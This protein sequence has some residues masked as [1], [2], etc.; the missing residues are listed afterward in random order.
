MAEV[1]IGKDLRASLGKGLLIR[2][3][4]N[5]GG[6]GLRRITDVR[7]RAVRLHIL[8]LKADAVDLT[9]QESKELRLVLCNNLNG[10]LVC[11]IL[12]LVITIRVTEPLVV[13]LERNLLV[14]LEE[15]KVVRA[16]ACGG[17]NTRTVGR[18]DGRNVR[19]VLRYFALVFIKILLARLPEVLLDKIGRT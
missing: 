12:T 13:T 3:E 6:V 2:V 4:R 5:L 15:R 11:L 8:T 17:L 19:A 16:V 7:A 14:S 10:N 9:L 1:L 18:G